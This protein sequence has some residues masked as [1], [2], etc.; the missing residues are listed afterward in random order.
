MRGGCV[1]LEGAVAGG[2]R[3]LT[4]GA[5]K[6]FPAVGATI[7]YDDPPYIDSGASTPSAS[8]AFAIV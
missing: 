5:L 1:G 7:E 3:A 6:T 8:S 4:A 2:S